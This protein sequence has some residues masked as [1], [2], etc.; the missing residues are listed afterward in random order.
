MRALLDACVLY[1]T[2]MREVLVGVAG[3]GLFAPLWSARILEEWARA[4][5]RNIPDQS[6]TAKAEIALLTARWPQAS[7][8]SD[9]RDYHLPDADDNHVLAAALNGRADTLVTMN[10]KDFPTRIVSPLGVHSRHPDSFLVELWHQNH[11]AVFGICEDVRKRAETLS[12][13][14]MDMRALL[15]RARL[16]RLGK[17]VG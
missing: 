17:L 1:P 3:A 4:V 2:V 6:H 8:G 14:D 7:F 13:E 15:K 10:L 11:A 12:G 5:A 16:P 9:G